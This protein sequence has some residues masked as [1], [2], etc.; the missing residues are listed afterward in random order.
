MD[1]ILNY[2]PVLFVLFFL[3]M[4]FVMCKSSNQK[5][6]KNEKQQSYINSCNKMNSL[7]N[8]KPHSTNEIEVV[9][10]LNG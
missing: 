2:Y 6:S 10:A 7:M 3:V 8:N 1:I 5:S 9:V 4:I